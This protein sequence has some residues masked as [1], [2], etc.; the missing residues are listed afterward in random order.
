MSGQ[1][2]AMWLAFGI[3]L[4]AALLLAGIF[5]L[6]AGMVGDDPGLARWGGAAWV[7]ILSFIIALPTIAPSIKRRFRG[8]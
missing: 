1:A 5:L 8:E 7:L 3:S 4:A 6:L 2:K